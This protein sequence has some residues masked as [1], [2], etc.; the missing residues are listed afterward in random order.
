M[1]CARAPARGR[2]EGW[3]ELVPGGR[4][5]MGSRGFYA[6]ESPVVPVWVG[7]LLVQA[8]LV[9][10]AEFDA[11]VTATGHRTV[12]ERAPLRSDFPDADPD[13]LVPGSLVFTPPPGPVAL[14][15]WTQWWSWVPGASWWSPQGLG[16]DLG[17]LADHPVVHVGFEDAVAYATWAGGRLA[18]EPEWEHAARGGLAGATYAWGDTF[19]VN[20]RPMANTFHGQ[21]PWRSADPDGFERTSPVGSYP[22]NGYGLFDLIGNV[23]EWTSSPWTPDHRNG[24]VHQSSAAM[25]GTT[26]CGGSLTPAE[27]LEEESLRVTKGGSHLCSPSYCRRYRP[28]ARQGQQVRSTTSHLGFR[29]VRPLVTP[30]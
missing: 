15:D 20:G 26:C 17:G 18:T 1:S 3:L 12:A 29:C 14:N 24:A 8:A 25:S 7:S 4:F 16:S 2:L 5:L 23:W 9:T 10:N 28:A 6:E 22:P 30:D 13:L 21:F 19:R 27:G 11:F